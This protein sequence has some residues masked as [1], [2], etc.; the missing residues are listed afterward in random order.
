MDG[1]LQTTERPAGGDWREWAEAWTARRSIAGTEGFAELIL[2]NAGDSIDHYSAQLRGAWAAGLRDE[3]VTILSDVFEACAPIG[4]AWYARHE[5]AVSPMDGRLKPRYLLF[6]LLI[7][8][9]LG[10]GL[11]PEEGER[12]VVAYLERVPHSRG[13]RLVLG[14]LQLEAGRWED[15]VATVKAI[16]SEYSLL[17]L[18]QQILVAMYRTR[19]R[20]E[21]GPV[22]DGLYIGDLTDR[23]CHV[24]FEELMTDSDGKAWTCCPS[25][26]PVPVGDI[27]TQ[28]W[29]SLWNS[30]VAQELRRS[31]LDGD[32]R[33]CSRTQ[34]PSILSDTLP[35]KNAVTDPQHRAAITS[36]VVDA[37]PRRFYFC[38][39]AT[40]NLACRQCRVGMYK[41][42]PGVAA[43]LDGLL[44]SLVAP[45]LAYGEEN[46]Y[47]LV[48][49]GNG[50]PFASD[51][52]LEILRRLDGETHAAVSLHLITNGLLF[53]HYWERLPNIHPLLARGYVGFSLDAASPEAYRETRGGSWE[54]LMENLVFL[55]EL[56]R[57]GQVAQAGINY[58]VQECNF[59]DMARIVE[60]SEQL[61]IDT[62]GFNQMRNHGTFPADEYQRR[63]VFE[64]SH[65]RYGEFLEELRHPILV[66][67]PIP[68][69]GSLQPHVLVARSGASR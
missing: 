39:D 7:D 40:C 68:T 56:R 2:G 54:K 1:S 45:I 14:E 34:C 53:K 9:I 61:G 38:H 46:E 21:D 10:D 18:P 28:D 22:V 33:H 42:E 55:G 27:Y 63:A 16:L 67:S 59:K 6:R 4:F 49:S 66:R 32:F 26:L 25:F 47:T 24:P 5:C 52:Y 36:R 48:I 8:R 31:V 64:P 65:P 23:F 57:S 51:H 62:V 50:D 41:A 37:K 19:Y 17:L 11:S 43:R 29:Q 15:G 3:A 20:P 44:E 58:A 69:F 30:D 13:A 35:Y 60:L 12:L